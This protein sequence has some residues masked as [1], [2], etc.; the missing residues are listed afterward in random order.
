MISAVKSRALVVLFA[1]LA[2]T[3]VLALPAQE[4]SALAVGQCRA[5]THVYQGYARSS[6][7]VCRTGHYG[8]RVTVTDLRSDGWTAVVYAPG[9]TM[10]QTTASAT[11]FDFNDGGDFFRTGIR[12]GSYHYSS[13][14]IVSSTAV[15]RGSAQGCAGGC[16]G[17]AYFIP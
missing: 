10:W 14:A 16:S 17:N 8:W 1:I 7:N 6:T 12:L 13:R 3:A 11:S 15:F 2:S 5:E 4:A 9:G